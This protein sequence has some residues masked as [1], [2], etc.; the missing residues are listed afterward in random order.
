MIV[1]Y[2]GLLSYVLEHTDVDSVLED[3]L[4]VCQVH[5]YLCLGWLLI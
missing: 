1:L 3:S 4:M 5:M 2:V